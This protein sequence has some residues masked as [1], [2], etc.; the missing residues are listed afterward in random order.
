MPDVLVSL[1]LGEPPMSEREG[2]GR[3]PPV[4]HLRLHPGPAGAVGVRTVGRHVTLCHAVGDA[5]VRGRTRDQGVRQ[6]LFG[7]VPQRR[8]PQEDSGR[9][10]R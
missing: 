9:P 2:P 6:V 7:M 3:S 5:R 10:A 8:C 1:V 4:T